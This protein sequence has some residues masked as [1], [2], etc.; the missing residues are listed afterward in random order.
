MTY[1]SYLCSLWAIMNAP[2]IVAT[3]I[4]N[5]TAQKASILLNS[6]VIAVNQDTLARAGDMIAN[7]SDTQVHLS[8][9]SFCS[10]LSVPLVSFRTLRHCLLF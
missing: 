10:F 9:Q 7:V 4:R 8:L 5:M 2:L 3:E 6:E 1:G